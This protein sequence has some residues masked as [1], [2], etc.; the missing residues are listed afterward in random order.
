MLQQQ[1]LASVIIVVWNGKAVLPVCLEKLSMQS[2]RAFEVIN[3]DNGSTN[4]ALRGIQ[5]EFPSPTLKIQQLDSNLGFA[6][7]NNLGARLACGQWLAL[8]NADAFPKPDWLEKL[9]LT[10]EQNQEYSP[11]ASRQV[12]FNAPDLLDGAGDAYHSSGL[13]WRNGYN[14]PSER[15]KLE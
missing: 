9:L 6:V 3:V 2:F 11:F 10:A 8:L 1:P 15:N 5:E 4:A 13:A 7:T 12:Q 14:L